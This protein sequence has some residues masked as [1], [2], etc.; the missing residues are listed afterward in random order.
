M[1]KYL[2][3][4]SLLILGSGFVFSKEEVPDKIK[5]KLKHSLL[6]QNTLG[7]RFIIAIPMNEVPTH[8]RQAL[9][10]YVASSENAQKGK[11]SSLSHR[12]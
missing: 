7:R 4:L 6:N 1:R 9:D 3:I 5:T 11:F 8:P 12:Q 2:L 10:I